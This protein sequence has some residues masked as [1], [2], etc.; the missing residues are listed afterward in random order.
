M[1]KDCLSNFYI[2]ISYNRDSAELSAW[3]SSAYQK[4]N[5][6]RTQSLDVSQDLDTTKDNLHRFFVSSP[7]ITVVCIELPR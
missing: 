5:N 6:F 4:L 2:Y 1:T 3:L 7:L